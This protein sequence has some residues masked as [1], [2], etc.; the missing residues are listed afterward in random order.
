MTFLPCPVGFVQSGD[1]CVCE[2]RLQR[3]TDQCTIGD[4]DDY[5]TKKSV[6]IYWIGYSNDSDLGVGLVLYPICP[7]KYCSSF[8]MNCSLTDLN[9]QCARNR[10]GMLCGS[11]TK[12]CSLTL[13]DSTCKK[14]SNMY[15]ILLIVFTMAGILL[16]AFLS[17]LRLTVATGKINSIILYANIVQANKFI[18]FPTQ[19]IVWQSSLPG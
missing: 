19:V 4:D 9:I 17:I 14:C 11:C 12:N 16:V 18:S 5:F 10:S 3:Y 7:V 15:L 1:E 8:E 2:D 13:G 6:S